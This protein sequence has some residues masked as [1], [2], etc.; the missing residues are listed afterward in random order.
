MTTVSADIK[1]T[2]GLREARA[3]RGWFIALGVGMIVVGLVASSNLFASTLASVYYIAA[4]MLAGAIMQVVHAF[5][6]SGWKQK[7][8]SVLSAIL[9][10]VAGA[11]LVHDPILSALDVTLIAGA[12]MVAAGVV[13]IVLGL[14]E[15]SHRGWGWILA[16]GVLSLLVGVLIISAWQIVGLWF[17]GLML[18]FDL[19]FQG[20]GFLGFGLSLQKKA[21]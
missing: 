15:R 21:S 5:T 17:L 20:C 7:S 2:N 8:V 1:I 10:G 14:R 12:F 13:R 3:N 11:F 9:Y 6:V 18:A 19:V 4:M 16:S